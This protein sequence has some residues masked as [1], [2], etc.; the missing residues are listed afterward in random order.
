MRATWKAGAHRGA[1]E[2]DCVAMKMLF[3]SK[4]LP[5]ELIKSFEIEALGMAS[6]KHPNLVTLY[7]ASARIPHLCLMQE[8]AP[9]GRCVS[10]LSLPAA[11]LPAQPPRLASSPLSS[12]VSSQQLPPLPSPVPSSSALPPGP[13]RPPPFPLSH[14]SP[15]P[16]LSLDKLLSKVPFA[17]LSWSARWAMAADCA[18][19][20]SYIHEQLLLHKDVKSPNFLVFDAPPSSRVPYLIKC[21]DFGMQEIKIQTHPRRQNGSLIT[22]GTFGATNWRAPELWEEDA[23]PTIQSDVYGLGCTMYE[24]A[25]HEIPWAGIPADRN[26]EIGGLVRDGYRP[27]RPNGCVN[28]F[29]DLVGRAWEGPPAARPAADEL[30]RELD[31]CFSEALVA[32]E[33]AKKMQQAATD[34]A[35]AAVRELVSTAMPGGVLSVVAAMRRFSF[36]AGVQELGCQALQN[37][38]A[39]ASDS[40]KLAAE[41][42]LQAVRLLRRLLSSPCRASLALALPWASGQERKTHTRARRRA[43]S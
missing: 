24:L 37:L 12:F 5:E 27:E 9:Y 39:T 11:R 13:R 26:M 21:A 43:G 2:D 38:A 14:S 31:K 20:V 28:A 36:H 22:T 33:Q 42:G 35:A 4:T 1:D 40:V 15:F 16:L 32:E 8:L 25:S 29:W 34:T 3:V 10:L 17:Q 41:Q 30:L 7:G 23:L 18:R 19:A 6:M